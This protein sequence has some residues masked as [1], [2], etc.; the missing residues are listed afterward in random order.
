MTGL[1]QSII[2]SLIVGGAIGWFVRG[3]WDG[4]RRVTRRR[5]ALDAG[6][7]SLDDHRRRRFVDAIVRGPAPLQGPGGRP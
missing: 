7:V 3:S 4:A 5:V 1:V 2:W 6:A